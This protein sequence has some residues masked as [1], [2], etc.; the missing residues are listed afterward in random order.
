MTF[1]T[2]PT[3]L[4]L[5]IDGQPFT[6]P[7]AVTGVVNIPRTLG[8]PSP[9]GSNVFVSWSDGG[10]PD[11]H[12]S[13]PATNTTYTATFSG[14]PT[15]TPTR[16]A[17][18]T[19]TPTP[20][21][22]TFTPTRTPTSGGPPT[23][24]PTRTPTPTATPTPGPLPPPW[25]QQDIGAVGVPGGAGFSG[26]SFTVN[27]SG[28]D[29]EGTADQFHYVY[30]P[31]SGD[32]T[33][34]ARVASIQNTDPWAK[35]GVMVRETLNAGSTHAM[36][37]LTPGNGLAFQRRVTTGGTTST[38][39]GANV[40]APYWVKVVRSGAT[41][42]GYSSPDGTNWTLVGSDTI[43]MGSSVFIGMPVTSHNNTVLC[44]ASIDNV[45][46]TG[47]GAP[48]PTATRTATRTFTPTPAP[49]TFTPT[50]TATKT[51][52]PTPGAPTST[53]TRTPTRTATPTPGPIPPPWAQQDIGAVGVPG[54]ATFSS[55]SFT[56][57]GS[58]S[59]IEGTSDQFHYVY[60]P[61]SGD[62]TIVARVASIQNTDPWAKGGV[63]IRETLSASSTHAMMVL[64][65]GN[66]LA[67]QRRVTTG[68]TTSTTLG[69]NVVA[70]YW[71]KVVRSGTTFTGYSSPDGINWTLV[72]SDTIAMGS[73]V[74]VGLPLTSHNNTMLCTALDR[75]RH[76]H[77]RRRT[78]ADRDRPP[79]GRSLRCRPSR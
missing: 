4:Q 32:V 9:Q 48:T 70:P 7:M 78:D 26:G 46:I 50:R 47:G 63:M 18:R 30:Q 42:T 73:S 68:G 33:I 15:P 31:V 3:G 22:P 41:F 72:G 65:P 23:S 5:T 28:S 38:T 79:L 27:G 2:N 60:E 25:V 12:I 34:V 45:T 49:P 24:T 36:M 39:L 76:D 75:Q 66:G 6:A 54:G 21:P 53:P 52:T 59:D 16:T 62:V 17:T 57:N 1:A 43:A 8:A 40:V 10:S 20:V 29:I 71:V 11:A 56:V 74:F 69:A 19:F 13:T 44:T 67:F 14:G 55:G 58:G 35:G 64:T 37:A 51:F 77:R 61:V